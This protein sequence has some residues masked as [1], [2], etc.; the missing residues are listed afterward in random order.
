MDIALSQRVNSIKPSAT[1]AIATKA[2]QLKAKGGDIISLSIG[3][4]DF[5]TPPHVKEAAIKGIQ[6][7]ATK[8]TAIDG[9]QEL[10]VAIQQKFQKDH[11]LNYTLDEILVS[12]GAKQSLYN[13]CQALLNPQDE[14]I[15]PAPYWV[16]Y[17]DMV[18]LCGATPVFIDTS[19]EHQFKI[20]PQ[21]LANA[22]TPNTRLVML[23]SPSNPSGMAYT[24]EETLELANV[25]L[26][27]PDILIVSDDIYEKILWTP[28]AFCNIVTVC[29]AL[30]ERT[31]VVNGVSKAY[32]MTGWR[33]GYAA[34]P[35]SLI[36]AMKKIQ[37][38][39]TSG[40]C[41]ISQKAA[42]AALTGDQSCV[43]TMVAAFKERHQFV[44]NELN[45]IP[46]IECL[47]SHGTFYAFPK[48]SEAIKTIN[49]LK[50]D[51]DFADY[52]LAKAGIAVVPGTAFGNPGYLRL[53]FATSQSLLEDALKRIQTVVNRRK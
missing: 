4:P 26:Q 19:I 40:P 17:P 9:T 50:N 2:R 28:Q 48:V 45:N 10:K 35:H 18:R 14:V 51:I 41:S 6:Q 21:Q 15:I 53:S 1:M 27:H 29:P 44:V 52:L 49:G 38:Q 22:I 39:S 23:N 34:G 32:A 11:Q 30:K 43:D 33:I 31:I 12:V 3:E 47:P 37:S 46:G 24:K 5:D 42:V 13:L 36:N 8:Y 16:S 7:G 25:L 20:T